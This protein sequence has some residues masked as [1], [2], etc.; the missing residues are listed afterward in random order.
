MPSAFMSQSVEQLLSR[1]ESVEREIASL[2]RFREKIDRRIAHL[3]LKAHPVIPL[4]SDAAV[5]TGTM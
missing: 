2:I 3:K 5:T 4:P 1:R